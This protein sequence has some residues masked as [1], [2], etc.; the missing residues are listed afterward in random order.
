MAHRPPK[1][2]LAPNALKGSCTAAAAAAAAMAR[3]IARALPDAML[4]ELPVADGGDGLAEVL[5]QALGGEQRQVGSAALAS[6]ADAA[7][8]WS[9]QRRT[10][11]IEMALASGLA[12][13]RRTSAT[14]ARPR[15]S[16]PAS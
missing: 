13:L 15:P 8:V 12:L 14:P 6:T 10:A 7:L 1:I 11:V 9:A 4:V 3:G 2:V 5:G 16:A